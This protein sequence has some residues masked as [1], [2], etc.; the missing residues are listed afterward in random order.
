M[1]ARLARTMRRDE[2]G[3]ALVMVI[4]VGSVLALL[5]VTAIAIGLGSA[6][7]SRNDQDWNGALAAAYAGVEEYQSRLAADPSYL[8]Y[9]NATSAFTP[10]TG[11]V[12]PTGTRTN[13]AFGVGAAQTWAAVPGSDG[14]ASYRYEVDASAFNTTGSLRLRS[15]GRVG[16]ETRTVVATLRINSFLDYLYFTD[17]EVEDPAQYSSAPL[18]NCATYA[19]ASRPTSC[20]DI[21]FGSNDVLEGPVHSNDTIRSCSAVFKGA[22]TTGYAVASGLPYKEVTSGGS[23]GCSPRTTF[24]QAGSP[25]TVTRVVMPA[26]NAALKLETRTDLSVTPGCLYTGPTT[27]RFHSNGQVTVRSP[28]T[29]ATR[30]SG[31]PATSGTAPAVCGTVGSGPGGLA[32]PGGATFTVPAN[33]VMYVQDV[34]AS[35]TDPNYPE[36]GRNPV[37][38]ASGARLSCT[39]ADGTADGNGIGYPMAGEDAPS[40]SSYLCNAGDAFVEGMMRGSVTVATSRY[41]YVT[42]N[43]TYASSTRDMLGLVGDGGVLVWNPVDRN[44]NS[45]LP[46]G[47]R[48][49]RTIDAAILSVQHTF[50]VQNPYVGGDRGTLTINGAIAQKFRGIVRHTVTTDGNT[51]ANGYAKDYN[52][53]TRFATRTPP[54]FLMPVSTTYD[55]TLMA[56]VTAAFTS[57]GQNG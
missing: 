47:I 38:S 54:K 33:N 37:I 42:S 5:V 46:S 29:R 39:S 48:T 40:A 52:Y 31:D 50:Q 18:P 41:I 51:R 36:G 6:R 28:W 15:T 10:D 2:N 8:N 21:A 19:Y 23:T 24:E 14:S 30:V 56:E 11:S 26:T 4:G 53:D 1:L 35:V 27:I 22:V 55:V 25:S 34:P 13:P 3:I 43:L 44:N 57:T 12:L 20:H 16:T 32:S 45:V 7:S 49:N 9:G 17:F